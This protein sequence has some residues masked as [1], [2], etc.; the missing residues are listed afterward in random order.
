MAGRNEIIRRL[1]IKLNG[2][3]NN[4]TDNDLRQLSQICDGLVDVLAETLENGDKI[5][6]KGFITAEVVDRKE[7]HRK[8]PKTNE[9][10]VVPKTKAIKC[11]MS[12]QIRDRIN[13]SDRE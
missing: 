3:A 10:I 11:R 9:I 5:K 8:H 7:Q 1:A 4:V 13:G 12:K 6:W 2:T